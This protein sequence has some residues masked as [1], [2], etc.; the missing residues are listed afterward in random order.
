[1]TAGLVL[2]GVLVL[3]AARFLVLADYIVFDW[4]PC[5]YSGFF[6][7]S[8][9]YIAAVVRDFAAGLCDAAAPLVYYIFVFAVLV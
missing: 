8:V 2:A 5:K 1:M 6:V 4:V 3:A 7:V 9:V